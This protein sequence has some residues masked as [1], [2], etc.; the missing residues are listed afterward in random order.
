MRVLLILN[1]HSFVK[2]LKERLEQFHFQVDLAESIKDGKYLIEM[3][4]YGLIIAHQNL[5]E[6]S[7]LELSTW[8]KTTSMQTSIIFLASKYRKELEIQSLRSGADDFLAEPI[9]LD[10]LL[11]RIEARLR[12]WG[13][14]SIQIHQLIIQPKDE[15]IFFDGHKI[16]IKG[17]A[18][19]ILVHLA[20]HR[21][22]II[23]KEELLDWIWEEPELVTP[24][25]IEVAINQ[26][27]Q[28]L[29]KTFG[30]KT[31]DTIR[32]RGYRFCY[33]EED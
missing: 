15:K 24:N 14:N 33:L 1:H 2:S 23:S 20:K 22:Q 6:G 19:Q 12:L 26:I 8:I 18:F 29:D 9:D 7:L 30:I 21:N 32:K 11:A 25:V 3:R 4:H 13:S 5:T 10:I 31:I 28:K 16:E 17:K 27:R